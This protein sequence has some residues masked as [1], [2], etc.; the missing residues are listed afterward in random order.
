LTGSFQVTFIDSH[1][2]AA[3]L[4]LFGLLLSA[5]SALSAPAPKAYSDAY[6]G[7]SFE[8]DPET[9][10]R[11]GEIYGS[12]CGACHDKGLN[13]APQKRMLALMTP[14]S[15]HRALTEGVMRAQATGLTETDK[16]AVAEYIAGRKSGNG[17]QDAPLMCAEGA[18]PFDFHEPPPFAGWG[19][20]PDSSHAIPTE[21]AGIDRKNVGK[22]TLKW[23]LAFPNAIRARSQ[24]TVAG[25]AI[26][27]GS[28]DG[29][30]FALDRATGC[31][32]WTF[33]AS[34]EVRTGI[35]VS[36]WQAGDAGAKPLVYFGD[37]IGNVYA[38]DARTG[39]RV[40]KTRPDPHP[41]ATITA[42]PVL[43]GDA[44]YVAVSSLE[45]GRG[46]DAQ[47]ECC[48]F[49]GSLNAYD[50]R[51]G[52]RRWQT[53]MTDPPVEQSVN[54]AGVK[55]F[56]PSGVALWNS[57]SVDE[58]RGRLYVATGD[59]YT[60]PTTSMSDAVVAFDMKTGKVVWVF[61]AQE[62]DAW[63]G[64]CDAA[65]KTNCPEENGPD[66]DFGAGT[67]LA[68][69]S[70]GRDYVLAGQKSG[71]LYAVNPDTGKLAWETR[72]GRGGVV[73]G[74][75]FGLAAWHG[76][77]FV[78]V[79]DVPDGRTYSEP[80]RPGLYAI[81]IA[82]GNYR[83]KA[84]AEDVCGGKPFCHP[85]YG[86]AITTTPELVLAGS[87]DGHLRAFDTATGKSLWDFDTARDF[88]TVNGVVAHGGSMGGGAAPIAWRGMLIMNSGYGFVGAM[89]G[90]V[91]MVFAVE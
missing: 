81:D 32:R 12:I 13:R 70:N 40:W 29:T 37:L 22:L 19:L 57:P 60:S 84:P 76:T 30:V 61:Q 31:A 3:M 86:G 5:G 87:N 49:R 68:R 72:V 73:A 69:A 58:K 38:V 51:T 26:F 41:N 28:H 50:A 6:K 25:G 39:Q 33:H 24:P 20:T 65:D 66:Y 79:S 88:T 74:I 71:I 85:G 42:A 44:L 91:L 52:Q 7:S 1:R 82:T 17:Q 14:E 8:L 62:G 90:N 21:K 59:N 80:P 64:A 15:I 46:T 53:F 63:N 2:Q 34:A 75:H 4:A 55:R 36:P 77:V 47:Y 27:V 10:K 18:S 83:W 43:H 89:N 67:V 11:G 56:G 78:P 48:V 35:V 9:A 45:E 16:V 54:A 23:S